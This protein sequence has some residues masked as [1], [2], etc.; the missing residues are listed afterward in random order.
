MFT[1]VGIV[2]VNAQMYLDNWKHLKSDE[3][4]GCCRRRRCCCR[5]RRCRRRRRHRRCRRRR[6]RSKN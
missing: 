4:L 5:R 6:R 3:E 1:T 2:Q